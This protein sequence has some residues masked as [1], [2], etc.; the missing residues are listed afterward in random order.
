MATVLLGLLG[1]A[2]QAEVPRLAEVSVQALVVKEI[3]ALLALTVTLLEVVEEVKV[4]LALKQLQTLEV[5]VEQVH[6]LLRSQGQG[7]VVALH[8]ALQQ[9]VAQEEQAVAAGLALVVF[10]L[11][12]VMVAAAA[13]EQAVAVQTSLLAEAA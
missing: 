11:V 1:L 4:A 5:T 9:Q 3:T 13:V 6:L 12:A 7:V 10:L 2:V 8:K